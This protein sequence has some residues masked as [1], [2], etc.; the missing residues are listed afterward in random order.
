MGLFSI[1]LCNET[2]EGKEKRPFQTGAVFLAC[3]L[4]ACICAN[5]RSRFP[6]LPLQRC[7]TPAS[8]RQASVRRPR[9][10]AAA[11]FHTFVR[12]LTRSE[13]LEQ[14][15][16]VAVKTVQCSVCP[17][18]AN[19]FRTSD[20]FCCSFIIP[21]IDTEK[22]WMCGSGGENSESCRNEIM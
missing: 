19:L 10:G 16:G 22:G 20:N 21:S 14:F 8:R 18:C 13:L 11:K 4:S 7:A 15:K 2:T 9:G 1:V 12:S 5:E 3:A 6:T 17:D